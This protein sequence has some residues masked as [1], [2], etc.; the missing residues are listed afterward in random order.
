MADVGTFLR[1]PSATRS[2]QRVPAVPWRVFGAV[3]GNTIDFTG[4]Q[5]AAF[6][7]VLAAITSIPILTYPW[8]PLSDYINHLARMHV[9]STVGSDPDLARYYEIDWTV[10][11]NL[12]MDL[13]VP[14]LE[15][16]MNVFV[17][18][19]IY[20]ISSFILIVSGTAALNRRLFGQWSVLPLIGFLLLYNNVFLV[21]TMNYIFGIGLSLWALVAWV[22]LRERGLTL[23]LAVSTLFVLGLFFCHLYA[24]GLYGLGLLAFES[25]R[26]L[27]A[28]RRTPPPNFSGF[29]VFKLAGDFV[30]T[31]IP[32]LPVVPLL[33]MSPTWG[34]RASFDWQLQGKLDGLIDVV[35]V[36]SPAVAIGL[37][38]I[39]LIGIILGVRYRTLEFHTFGWVLLI[40]AAITYMALPR[41]IFETY[42]ADT[43]LPLSIAF[44]VIACAKLNLRDERARQVFAT[45]LV[46]LLGLRIFE[47]ETVWSELSVSMALFRD[48]VNQLPRG[49]KV[50]V[51]YGDPKGGD[52]LKDL[53]LVHAACLAIIERSALVTTAFT[54]LGKQIMHVTP[55][56]RERVDDED[57]TPPTIRK[58]LK[59]RAGQGG[60][61]EYW[62]NWTKDYDYLYVVFTKPNHKNPDPIRLK[63]TYAGDRFA[64]YQIKPSAGGKTRRH[65]PPQEPGLSESSPRI[66]SLHR[67]RSGHN[68]LPLRR[69]AAKTLGPEE[70]PAE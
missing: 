9:I 67:L 41:V 32:F 17:A 46:L 8:P 43:R 19:Q 40:V 37:A 53:G 27:L 63:T 69:V 31:G 18:G 68:L 45:I 52:D 38:A 34:L 15:R 56:Y 47:V 30:A 11:P 64:L 10:L 35:L 7:L 16:L 26:L 54:V 49:S 1:A 6:F 57:G 24:V 22:W 23:R 65:E 60:D 3:R 51:T 58:L 55:K 62:A 20:T 12:M 21:G 50:L 25:H 2:L 39:L 4:Q 29:D 36:Y 13:V 44:M 70:L 28:W 61:G 14:Q 42:M 66:S 33:M 48:S 59:Q 5:I